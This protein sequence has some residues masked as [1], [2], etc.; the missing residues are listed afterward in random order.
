MVPVGPC[1]CLPMMI[2]ALPC[3]FSMSACQ[4]MNSSLPSRGWRERKPAAL[5]DIEGDRLHLPGGVHDSMKLW[6]S[7]V[8]PADLG[9]RNGRLFGDNAGRQLLGR[10]FERE[11]ADD[12]AINGFP[13]A[14]G[15]GL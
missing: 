13:G 11:K 2:S 10:H 14:V 9:G 12:A 6:L 15:F 1:R 4:A 5:V 3:A 8:A 7:D